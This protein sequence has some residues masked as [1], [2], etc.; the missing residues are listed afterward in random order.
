MKVVKKNYQEEVIADEKKLSRVIMKN[1]PV[2]LKF[3]TELCRELKNKNIAKAESFLNDITEQK[4]YLPLRKFNKRVAHRKGDSQSGVKSGR[5]PLN[6]AKVFIEL[7]HSLKANAD[8]K[9]LDA[10]KL[11]I[12]SIFASQGL[13]RVKY[14]S[15]GRIS[16]KK[17]K[18]KSVHI[19]AIA[20]EGS[21]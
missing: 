1:K 4:R 12:K 3:S 10:D 11:I 14:Q 15:Q 9:G 17:R 5:Y 6:T 8:Y 16:G 13:G 2:S 7:V 21:S 18:K 20:V 19:E